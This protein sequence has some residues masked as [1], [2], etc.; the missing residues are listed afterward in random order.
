[1]QII[2]AQLHDPAPWLEWPADDL[3]TRRRILTEL[4][5]AWIDALGIDAALLFPFDEEWAMDAAGQ[6]PRRL[7]VVLEASASTPD[8]DGFVAGVKR[9]H[10]DGAVGLRAVASALWSADSTDLEELGSGPIDVDAQPDRDAIDRV[11]GGVFDELFAACQRHQV[12]LFFYLS[13]YLPLAGEVAERYPDLTLVVDHFGLRQPPVDQRT[14]PPFK[15]L[16]ELLALGRYPNVAVKFSG[17]P[18]LSEAPYPY[19]DLWP[20]LMQVVEAFGPERLMWASDISRFYGRIGYTYRSE[21]SQ[22]PYP[23]KH[24]YA[25]ALHFILDTDELSSDDKEWILGGTARRL[26]NWPTTA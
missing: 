20:H 24:S 14:T 22:G 11:R 21:S 26:L 18:S 13:G 6:F 2:D 5:L 15:A 19:P 3:E 1:M 23:G 9:Q 7:G 8:L 16:P 12:P 17:A 4:T 25:E 10:A